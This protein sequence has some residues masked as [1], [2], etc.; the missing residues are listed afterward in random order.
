MAET[1]SYTLDAN[2]KLIVENY[3]ECFHCPTIHPELCVVS[4]TE[5]GVTV[6]GDGLFVG[7]SDDFRDG[8]ETMSL[9]G[10]SGGVPIPGLPD[11]L[12]ERDALPAGRRRTCWSACHPDYVMIH[13]LVPLAP[14]RTFVECQWLFPQSRCRPAGVRPLVRRRLLGHH[15]PP[16]LDGV[17]ERAAGRGVARAT[18]PVRSRRT[19]RCGVR[20][21]PSGWP[22]RMPTGV[23]PTR[24]ADLITDEQRAT[25]A[26][27]VDS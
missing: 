27:P 18:V 2:W 1:H 22:R 23:A 10:T 20:R 21:S 26:F 12:P 13:R 25:L 11:K 8:V 16:G 15:E 24:A 17:R 4:D 9:D 6:F 14:D 7:G 5:A 19:T 3:H